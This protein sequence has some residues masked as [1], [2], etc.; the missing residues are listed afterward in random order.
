MSYFI[1][2]AKDNTFKEFLPEHK[3]LDVGNISEYLIE[4]IKGESKVYCR[5]RAVGESGESESSNIIE[6]NF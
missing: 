2:V 1:D 3:D 5:I 4:D 6:V